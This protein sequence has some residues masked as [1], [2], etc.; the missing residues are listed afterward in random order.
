VLTEDVFRRM[1][2]EK[3]DMVCVTVPDTGHTPSLS[4][5]QATSALDAFLQPL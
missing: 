2:L 4:E 1:A 5:P 3:P